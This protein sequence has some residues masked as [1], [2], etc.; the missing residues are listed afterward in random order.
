MSESPNPE[1]IL[2]VDDEAYFRKFVGQVVKKATRANVVEACD[3]REGVKV[4]QE[5]S[6]ALVLLDIS[7]PH[8]DGLK[9]LTAMRRISQT[10]PIIMLTAL[11]EEKV[12][13]KCVGEGATFFIRKDVA[14]AELSRAL[15]DALT[16]Y[17]TPQK[18]SA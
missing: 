16:E 13:E 9:T 7:M 5:R 14:A 3:G 2:L 12:V 8:M 15:N 4:F 11:S 18:P 10:V 17:L 6:P 1:T